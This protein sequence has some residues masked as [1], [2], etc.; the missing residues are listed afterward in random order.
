MVPMLRCGLVRTNWLLAMMCVF[1]CWS[2]D[3]S[4]PG[5][6]ARH[7]RTQLSAAVKGAGLPSHPP[8]R[9][10]L[11]QE[12]GRLRAPVNRSSEVHAT[13]PVRVSPDRYAPE[14]TRNM[15]ITVELNAALGNGIP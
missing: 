15:S 9:V 4:C 2:E 11:Q 3:S 14:T 12:E 10:L 5:P 7:L 6:P 13:A 8:P 1:P